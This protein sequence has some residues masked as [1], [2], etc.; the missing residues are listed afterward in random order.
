MLF[1]ALRKVSYVLE[2]HLLITSVTLSGLVLSTF[3]LT[4]SLI[5]KV[6]IFPH[7]VFMCS[8]DSLYNVH[9]LVTV[10]KARCIL[11]KS[12]SRFLYAV[13]INFSLY[14]LCKP[15]GRNSGLYMRRDRIQVIMCFVLLWRRLW[16]N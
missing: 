5:Q 1:A 6:C 11:A 2:F 10:I 4:T 13:W 12:R 14:I 15:A 7:G 8:C 16:E 3:N 9:R